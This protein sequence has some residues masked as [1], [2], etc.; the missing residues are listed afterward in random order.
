MS[1]EPKIIAIYLPQFH[2]TDFNNNNWGKGYTEW[3]A[4]QKSKPLFKNH[5]QPRVPLNNN[6]YDLS[7]I[8]VLN[9]QAKLAKKYGLDGFAVYQYYSK[10]NLLLNKPME[11]LLAHP[12]VDFHFYFFWANEEWRKNWFGQDKKVI[13]PQEYGDEQDWQEHYSYCRKFFLDN[14]Y[15]KIDNKPVFFI[16]HPW[17]FHEIKS[18]MNLWNRLAVEDG[19]NGVFFVKNI[20]ARNSKDLDGFD[21][22]FERE[23]FYE[24]G[25]GDNPVSL[26]HRLISSRIWEKTNNKGITKHILWKRDYD[27]ACR[28]IVRMEPAANEHTILGAFSGWDNTPRK[29]YNGCLFT[30][31]NAQSF[32]ECLEGQIKK[33]KKYGCPQIVINAWNEWA[34]GMYLEPDERFKYQFLEAVK[35]AKDN[36]L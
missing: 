36:S 33:A 9:S 26:Y 23:P 21:G 29:G 11:M 2:E 15:I 1:N 30:D 7:D 25:K 27:Q 24:L 4:C 6:Y 19:F 16:Y 12:E 20:T 22:V 28:N 34:E 8:D 35:C 10:G 13:W 32:E 5:Y 3:T 18:F 31:V 17:D 14:R